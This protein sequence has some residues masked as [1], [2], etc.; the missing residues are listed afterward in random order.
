VFT[1]TIEKSVSGDLAKMRSRAADWTPLS[2][3]FRRSVADFH[4]DRRGTERP[5]S[6]GALFDS[7]EEPDVWRLTPNQV[8]YG[9]DISYA[10]YYAQWRRDHGLS[11]LVLSSPVNAMADAWAEYITTGRT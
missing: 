1:V 8:T 10:Q 7:V 6:S 5:T 3:L 9:T 2:N 11:E 4:R